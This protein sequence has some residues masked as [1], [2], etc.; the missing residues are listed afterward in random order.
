MTVAEMNK[1]FANYVQ[2]QLAILGYY[3]P[4]LRVDGIAGNGTLRGFDS[5]VL[6]FTSAKKGVTDK[7][8]ATPIVNAISWKGAAKRVDE[9][10]YGVIARDIGVTED[11][12]RAVVEVEASGRGFDSQGRVKMLFE[13]H[14]FYAELAGNLDQRQR[15]VSAKL[16]YRKWGEQPYPTDSY[17]RFEQAI[18]INREAAFRSC[19]WGAGQIL[20][21][22]HLLCGYPSA[23][24]M[25]AA[26]AEDEEAH[27][28]A[29]ADFIVSEGLDVALKNKDWRAFAFR[30][31]GPGYAKNAYDKKLATAYAKWV[32]IPDVDKPK[33]G[34]S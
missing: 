10:D 13:P 6:D 4:P 24:S 15:A 2:R 26:F 19:S 22:N 31:N 33:D 1:A 5:L 21:R 23:E 29:M 34:L 28:K 30:Y 9:W 32:K 11:H 12:M 3:K 25:V 20:G 14:V 18:T 8:E 7:S 17:P 16:A 27:I